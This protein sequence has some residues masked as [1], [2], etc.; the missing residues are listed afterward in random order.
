MYNNVTYI[1]LPV[2][3]FVENKVIGRVHLTRM[4]RTRNMYSNYN[5]TRVIVL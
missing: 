4:F 3:G 2:L 5:N 1:E